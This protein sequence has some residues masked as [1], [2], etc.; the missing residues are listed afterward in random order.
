MSGRRWT[1]FALRGLLAA[2]AGWLVRHRCSPAV[3][4]WRPGGGVQRVAGELSVRTAGSGDQ[5]VV[6]L[7]GLTASGDYF[8]DR[9]D[10]LAEGAQLVFPDLL[11]FGRS[12][13]VRRSD[14][15]LQAH[16]A[17][18][19]AMARE[20]RLDGRALTVAGH[21]FGALLA[22]HWAA[23]RSDVE[24]VV[25]FSAP[26][27]VD[28]EEADERIAAMGRMEQLFAPQ[29]RASRAMCGWMC[30]HRELA[31]WIAV[32]LEPQ[33]PLAIARKAV[34][35]SWA[36]YVGAMN[37]VIRSGGWQTALITLQSANVNVLLAD[38]AHDPVQAP[39][40]ASELA[41]RYRNVMTVSNPTARHQLPITH[42]R[43]CV[44]QL[45]RTHATG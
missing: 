1:G 18:L 17:A 34:R 23:R 14:Y 22:L 24:R 15:S 31:E 3:R 13:D 11:G 40:R 2:S 33:W 43:W 28:A 32:A 4:S 27:Y 5:V 25:C 19:D 10:Q 8:G 41:T 44:N 26:L 29:G 20:L 35:H 7:H 6:L 30:R 37:G 9:Y 12:L 42:P 21:S 36:S 38:G 45:T 39:S 16:L